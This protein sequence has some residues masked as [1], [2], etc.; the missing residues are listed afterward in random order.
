MT[1]ELNKENLEMAGNA[2]AWTMVMYFLW[3]IHATLEGVSAK[4][5]YV[6]QWMAQ[7][8]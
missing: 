8:N 7:G 2:G 4:I 5:D 3:Q 6:W 1:L